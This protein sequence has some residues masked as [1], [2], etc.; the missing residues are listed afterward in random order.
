M[1][2]QDPEMAKML[3]SGF[4]AGPKVLVRTEKPCPE[5]SEPLHYTEK[6]VIHLDPPRKRVK[7]MACQYQGFVPCE[8]ENTRSV[9]ITDC[10]TKIRSDDVT[11][12]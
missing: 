6:G 3:F 8:M 5:C 12:D 4:A 2:P 7:C 11:E 1:I 9:D 10:C